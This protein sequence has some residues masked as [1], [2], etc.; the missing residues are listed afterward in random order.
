MEGSLATQQA[1]RPAA[2]PKRERDLRADLFRGLAL[3]FIFIDHV[4]GNWL[5][6]LTIRNVTLC[7]ATEVF[8]LLAG[9]AAGIAY[10]GTLLREGWLF[11][12]AQVVRR[13]G[14]LYVAH[15][16]LFVMFTAQVGYSAAALQDSIYIDELHL[17]AFGQEPYRALL[18]ALLLRF[19]PA[20]LNILPLYIVLLLQFALTLPLLRRPRLLLAI[21]C[22][23]YGVTR[24]FSLELPSWT[25]G[26]WFFNPFAWQVLFCVGL[27][28]GYRAPGGPGPL[29]VLPWWRSLGALAVAWLIVT[30]VLLYMTWHRPEYAVQ[31]PGW[32]MSWWENVDK[33]ALH[34]FRLVSVLALTYLL[35]HWVRPEARWLRGAAAWPFVLMGKQGLPVFCSGILFAFFARLALEYSDD[36]PMQI[37]AN[38]AGL[39]S[40][41]AVG[42][43]SDWYKKRERTPR[44]EADP[45]LA[46]RAA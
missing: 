23:L 3:W 44:R 32:V 19:Q 26:G 45:A 1:T 14:S 27:T 22:A 11:A 40:L 4:P 5:A 15:I 33:T 41:V 10:G 18:E 46:E 38:L 8:V 17:D 9:Y 39:A 21:S 43:L 16:V 2:A 36:A 30:F 28:L 13:V 42:W 12:A 37:G 34:P 6:N 35:A 7:D 24:W 29:L 20:F 31:V 25:G